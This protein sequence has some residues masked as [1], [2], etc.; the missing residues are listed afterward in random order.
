MR[1]KQLAVLLFYLMF[2]YSGV[3]KIF[4]FDKKVTILSGKTGLPS[5]INI[6]GMIGVIILEIFGSILLI[7]D[8]FYDEDDKKLN[9]VLVEVT[10]TMYLL[11]MIVVTFLYHP[12]HKKIIPFLSNLTTFAAMLYMYNDSK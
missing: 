2:L 12:P 5:I 4:T 11:F 10:K 7:Y 9:P 1:I 3:N 8:S 6:L